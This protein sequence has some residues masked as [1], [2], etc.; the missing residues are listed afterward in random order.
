MALAR[1]MAAPDVTSSAISLGSRANPWTVQSVDVRSATVLSRK[2]STTGPQHYPVGSGDTQP[3]NKIGGLFSALLHPV[4]AVEHYWAF[5]A[6]RAE[7][8]L[9]AHEKHRQ[10]LHNVSVAH[11]QRH[12]VSTHTV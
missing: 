9:E 5:R 6:A 10:D 7:A 3:P 12:A 11:E 1:Q 2:S 8:L 4:S